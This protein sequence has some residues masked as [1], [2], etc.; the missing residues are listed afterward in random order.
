LSCEDFF[1]RHLLCDAFG[2]VRVVSSGLVG[3]VARR[4]FENR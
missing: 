2:H 1:R 3:R 4:W